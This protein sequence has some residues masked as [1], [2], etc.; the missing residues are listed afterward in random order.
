MI[1]GKEKVT[2]LRS[3][4]ERDPDTGRMLRWTRSIKNVR[5]AIQP[6]DGSDAEL[7]PDG[8]RM[9]D[10]KV[11]FSKTAFLGYD[12]RTQQDAD[13]VQFDDGAGLQT[14]K[15][16]NVEFWRKVLR[17]YRVIVVLEKDDE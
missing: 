11:L 8:Y 1:P 3:I 14:W 5:A 4:S 2:I 13:R 6:L 12:S 15:V 17:H 10:T 9:E 7:V 16:V